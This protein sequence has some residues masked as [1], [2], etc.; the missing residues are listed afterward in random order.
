[1][2]KIFFIWNIQRVKNYSLCTYKDFLSKMVLSHPPQIDDFEIEDLEK[3]GSWFAWLLIRNTS[4]ELIVGSQVPLSLQQFY[5]TK[6]TW[7]YF[8]I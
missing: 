2:T 8:I 4:R 6:E 7:K 3:Y 1:M 5:L